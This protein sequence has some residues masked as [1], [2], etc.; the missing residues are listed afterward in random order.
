VHEV[1]N[2]CLTCAL[3]AGTDRIHSNSY[4]NAHLGQHA[5][6]LTTMQNGDNYLKDGHLMPL[7]GPKRRP[8]GSVVLPCHP[9]PTV[10]S[11][12]GLFYWYFAH[13]TYCL[14]KLTMTMATVARAALWV[15]SKTEHEPGWLCR[16]HTGV[17]SGQQRCVDRIFSSL[18][19]HGD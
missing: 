10:A 13:S 14:F 19:V 17:V 18:S 5:V 8:V 7:K 2:A 16:S 9:V 3:F 1:L 12:A 11:D 6:R 15:A 4:M